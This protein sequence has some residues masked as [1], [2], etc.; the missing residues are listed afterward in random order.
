MKTIPRV[1]WLIVLAGFCCMT[2]VAQEAGAPAKSKAAKPAAQSQACR[3]QSL[4]PK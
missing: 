1:L 4:R 2:L 3:C